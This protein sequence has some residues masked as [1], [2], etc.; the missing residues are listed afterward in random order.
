MHSRVTTSLVA[1]GLPR[2]Q[3][4]AEAS[5]FSQ[6]QGTTGSE[7]TIP[8]YLRL[9]FAHASSTVFYAMAGIMAVAA[10][11]A[12]VGLERGLQPERAVS[13]TDGTDTEVR[14]AGSPNF[15]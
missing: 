7:A 11:L 13:E 2:A 8:H 1:Q 10:V 3:A 9:D 14:P 6:S 12:I 5:R 4:S 15:D